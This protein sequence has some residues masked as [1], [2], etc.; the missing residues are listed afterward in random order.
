MTTRSGAT[1]VLIS[2]VAM[3]AVWAGCQKPLS[4]NCQDDTECGSDYVCHRAVEN[5]VCGARCSG[6]SNE[7]P[8]EGGLSPA[9]EFCRASMG[10]D[11]D[12]AAMVQ[13]A[14]ADNGHC[15]RSNSCAADDDCEGDLICHEQI[16]GVLMG[17]TCLPPCMADSDCPAGSACNTETHKCGPGCEADPSVCTGGQ[18]CQVALGTP[19]PCTEPCAEGGMGGFDCASKGEYHCDVAGGMGLCAPGCTEDMA[20]GPGKVCHL[21]AA[22]AT[23]NFCFPPCPATDC[24]LFDGNGVHYM[25][26]M[27]D[28][29]CVAM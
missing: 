21:V 10:T 22:G 20:C 13:W 2:A 28:G 8:P 3:T 24:S 29:H 25:C 9:A 16:A 19:A 26:S 5:G 27:A 15:F 1:A 12:D 14:C 17:G 7:V 6:L 4:N 11:A 18:I 23:T